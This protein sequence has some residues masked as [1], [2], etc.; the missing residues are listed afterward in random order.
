[1]A[2][3]MLYVQ[4]IRLIFFV[5]FM[6]VLSGCNQDTHNHPEL[7]TGKQFFDYHC[8]ACHKVTGK[9]KFLKGI[10]ANKNTELTLAEVKHKIKEGDDG[11]SQMPLF[12]HMSDDEAQKI[13]DYLKQ[14]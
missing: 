5:L 4:Y 11:N 10:P 9:G 2:F 12:S 3:F 6:S 7:T 14:I 13:S 8:S 1:M